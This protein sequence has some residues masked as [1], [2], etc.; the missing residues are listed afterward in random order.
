MG[1]LDVVTASL[2]LARKQAPYDHL[3]LMSWCDFMNYVRRECNP[4]AGE[5]HC[6]QLIQQLQLQGEVC[7]GGRIALYR[8][9]LLRSCT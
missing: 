1:L 4:L 3:P 7:D 2:A 8:S 5:S 9:V 6:K